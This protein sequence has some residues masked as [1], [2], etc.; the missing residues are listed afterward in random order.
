LFLLAERARATIV[1]EYVDRSSGKTGKRPQLKLF[2]HAEKQKFNLVVFWSLDRFSR[3]STLQT[4]QHL[5]SYPLMAS[6]GDR[7]KSRIS[8]ACGPF[9]DVV[10]SL[11]ATLAKQERIRISERTRAGLGRARPA[12]QKR[13]DRSGSRSTSRN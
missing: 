12:R 1:H 5:R 4:L 9:K 6:S 7:C 11:M 10:I 2:T 8:T 3:E 13:W